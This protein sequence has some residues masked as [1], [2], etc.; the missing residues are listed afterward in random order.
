MSR[1]LS[2]WSER[3]LSQRGYCWQRKAMRLCAKIPNHIGLRSDELHATSRTSRRLRTWSGDPGA[4]LITGH[5]CQPTCERCYQVRELHS[6]WLGTG[7]PNSSWTKNSLRLSQGTKKFT[8]FPKKQ[9]TCVSRKHLRKRKYKYT[10]VEIM[11]GLHQR[12]SFVYF[13]L[14]WMIWLDAVF[15]EA[16]D[17]FDIMS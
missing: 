10:S 2:F 5:A 8:A 16:S 17:V 6:N 9:K 13:R 14:P 3:V 4:A 11:F 1:F 15:R 12:H 7:L